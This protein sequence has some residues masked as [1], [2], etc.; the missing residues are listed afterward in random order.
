MAVRVASVRRLPAVAAG[1]IQA[2]AVG[3]QRIELAVH[4]VGFV[5]VAVLFV[6]AVRAV[7]AADPVA[8]T[9][10]DQLTSTPGYILAA[11]TAGGF[12]A[13]RLIGWFRL[14]VRIGIRKLKKQKTPPPW[15]GLVLN[16]ALV[17]F[18][19]VAALLLAYETWALANGSV[20]PPIT[21]YVRC[22]AYHQQL[23]AIA[24]ATGIG[25]IVSNWIWFP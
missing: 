24:T 7:S 6:F 16:L 4:L 3:L 10:H 22:A 21:S 19:V 13:G 20:P 17:L 25:F 15:L 9:K 1:K 5:V 14:H 18:L 8:C 23:V 2:R 11:F 12:V